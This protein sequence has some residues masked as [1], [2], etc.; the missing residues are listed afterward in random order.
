MN[1]N[2]QFPDHIYDYLK[3]KF[4]GHELSEYEEAWAYLL[5]MFVLE[6]D[7]QINTLFKKGVGKRR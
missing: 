3:D 6:R 5:A 2:K 4:P 1:N 7:N